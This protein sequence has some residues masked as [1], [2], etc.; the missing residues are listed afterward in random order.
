MTQAELSH[1]KHICKPLA[2]VHSMLYGTAVKAA[3]FCSLPHLQLLCTKF[4]QVSKGH[5]R[6]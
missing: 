3:L 1:S 4:T 5:M 2:L 6:S